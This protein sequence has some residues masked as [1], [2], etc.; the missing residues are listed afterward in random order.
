MLKALERCHRNARGKLFL[1]RA[2]LT[3]GFCL[4]LIVAS[5]ADDKVVH[6][7]KR[8]LQPIAAPG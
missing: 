2:W 7:S 8:P 1:S 6:Q 5:P 4:A 3:I